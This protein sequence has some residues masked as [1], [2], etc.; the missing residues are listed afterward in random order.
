MELCVA[1][2]LVSKRV[3]EYLKRDYGS[4]FSTTETPDGYLIKVND[5]EVERELDMALKIMDKY[6][7][8]LRMLA[9]SDTSPANTSGRE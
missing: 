4:H 5:P 1:E 2:I 6:E 9:N 8:T 7:E 3:L